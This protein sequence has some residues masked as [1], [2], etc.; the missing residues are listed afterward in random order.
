MFMKQCLAR[1]PLRAWRGRLTTEES[2]LVGGGNARVKQQNRA[3]REKI[4][5]QMSVRR[6]GIP[7]C[8]AEEFREGPYDISFF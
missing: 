8:G 6:T 7:K 2:L 3:P 1:E 5:M 4:A